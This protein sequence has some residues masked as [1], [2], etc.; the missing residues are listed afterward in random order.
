MPLSLPCKLAVFAILCLLSVLAFF[1]VDR[2]HEVGEQ[3]LHNN[4]F[5]A[6][7]EGWQAQAPEEGRVAVQQG[8]VKIGN[9][10]TDHGFM[11][12]FLR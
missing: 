8:V 4:D 3:L 5:S 2:Y 10:G 11:D 12:F 6:G 9:W 1:A 7:L